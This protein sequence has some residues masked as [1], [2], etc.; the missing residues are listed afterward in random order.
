MKKAVLEKLGLTSSETRVYEILLASEPLIAS[1]IAKKSKLTRTNTYSVLNKL[2]EKDLIE[3]ISR[4]KKLTYRISHPQKLLSYAEK[5]EKESL[6]NTQIIEN[7]LPDMISDYNLINNKPGISHYEGRKGIKKLFDDIVR[8]KPKELLIFRSVENKKKVDDFL[9]E[10]AKRRA[11]ADIKTR[12]ISPANLTKAQN[13]KDRIYYKDRAY[14]PNDLFGIYT[15]IYI[16][17]EKVSFISFKGNINGTLIENPYLAGAL[18][19]I[20]NLVWQSDQVERKDN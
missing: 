16:Y 17:A 8:E 15:Q 6:E 18:G 20:F 2:E 4:K 13:L 14:V 19:A 10:E 1:D 7:M 5:K 12:I 3:R 9:A 11:S